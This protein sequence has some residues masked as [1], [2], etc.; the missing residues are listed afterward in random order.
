MLYLVVSCRFVRLVGILDPV[1]EAMKPNDTIWYAVKYTVL[2]AA[3]LSDLV[4]QKTNGSAT[5]TINRLFGSAQ[6]MLEYVQQLAGAMQVDLKLLLGAV[7][8]VDWLNIY[9]QIANGA[10]NTK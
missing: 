1:V 3:D 7:T 5:D 2:V 8:Q 9:D 10:V 4:Q 6:K